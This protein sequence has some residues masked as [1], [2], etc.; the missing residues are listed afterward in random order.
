MDK[1]EEIIKKYSEYAEKNGFSLNSDRK[2]VERIVSGLLKN[3]AEKGEQ[4]CPCRRLSGD[5]EE[6][7]KKICPCDYHKEEIAE[8]G[9]CYCGLF[10]R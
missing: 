2:V 10:T 1:I 6:D 3:E 5:P 4:Y 9:R 8:K 7:A